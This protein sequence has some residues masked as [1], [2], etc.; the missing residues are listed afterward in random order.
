M[1]T[2]ALTHSGRLHPKVIVSDSDNT[3]HT[4]DTIIPYLFNVLST[5]PE[6]IHILKIWSDGPSSQSQFK[7]KYIAAV[8]GIFEIKFKIKI[9]WNFF[10]TSHGKG[11]VDV[12]G[13]IVKQ[14]ASRIVRSRQA[15][16]NNAAEF[17]RAYNKENSEIDVFELTAQQMDETN[18]DLN[19]RDVFKNALSIPDIASS[20][21]LQR[22]Q[23]KI[24]GFNVS[25][26]GY[27]VLNEKTP[28][29]VL[30]R[31]NM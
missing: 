30:S 23:K 2:I 28:R 22:V 11:C 17:V 27:D 10:A 1:F 9:I 26:I 6:G 29:V 3:C 14:R 13:A 21:Q 19:I 12:L 7:N 18:S 15:T 25:S 4:K 5:L 31:I 20:H 8:I 16:C 24:V